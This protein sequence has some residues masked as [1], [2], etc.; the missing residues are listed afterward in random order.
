MKRRSR[1]F[2]ELKYYD[3]RNIDLHVHPYGVELH[4]FINRLPA[5]VMDAL[6]PLNDE[7]RLKT[8]G[9]LSGWNKSQET[10]DGRMFSIH[11]A[12]LVVLI[13]A[14]PMAFAD[15]IGTLTHELLHVVN[16]VLQERGIHLNDSSEEA[17]AYLQQDLLERTLR[18]ISSNQ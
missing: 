11:I 14:E 1:K 5:E 12:R 8:L 7:E 13:H 10:L 9:Y 2:P 18:A 17:Y 15:F 3:P 16:K 6:G 4:I